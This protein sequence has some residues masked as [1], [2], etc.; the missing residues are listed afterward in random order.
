[1]DPFVLHKVLRQRNPARYAA[2]LKFDANNKLCGDS[3]ELKD[4]TKQGGHGSVAICFSSPERFLSVLKQQQ[5]KEV[6]IS[7]N[8]SLE[9]IKNGKSNVNSLPK[10]YAKIKL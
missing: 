1:M 6:D 4:V 7:T 9:N 3:L 8:G 10:L 2:F 5:K